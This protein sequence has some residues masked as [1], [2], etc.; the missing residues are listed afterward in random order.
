MVSAMFSSVPIQPT[1]QTFAATFHLAK[2][3][4][5]APCFQFSEDSTLDEFFATA[6]SSHGV[7]VSGLCSS[8]GIPNIRGSDLG[9]SMSSMQCF[10]ATNS[11]E[12]ALVSTA[13]C[14][15]LCHLTGA[16]STNRMCPEW[17]LRVTLSAA[18]EASTNAVVATGSPLG[19]G[20]FL[21]DSSLASQQ[22]SRN[23]E[24]SC[25]NCDSLTAGRLGSMWRVNLHFL[26][27]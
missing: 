7:L 3:Q 21:G 11:K 19:L 1:K 9:C 20:N 16:R 5:T 10:I 25:E 12:K 18:C 23:S 17:D 15:L 4:A 26:S 14:L 2:W 8:S 24:V 6:S 13:F 22:C 27:K